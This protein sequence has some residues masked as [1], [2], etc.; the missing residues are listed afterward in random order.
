[1]AASHV[2]QTNKRLW[3]EAVTQLL[4]LSS[5]TVER[6]AELESKVAKLELELSVWKD[7]VE[8]EQKAHNAQVATL[9]HQLA[10][11]GV[12]NNQDPLILC[13]LDGNSS[14]FRQHLLAQG[15]QGGRHAAQELTKKI[16]EYLSQ[17]GVQVY[18]RLSFWI[19]IYINKRRLLGILPNEGICTGEQLDS[20]LSGFS[21]ASARFLVVDVGQGKDDVDVKLKEY[22]QTYLRFPQTLKVFFGGDDDTYVPMLEGIEKEKLTGKLVLLEGGRDFRNGL[23]QFALPS[24]RVEELFMPPGVS[25]AQQRPGP[26]PL[27]GFNNITTVGGLISPQSETQTSPSVPPPAAGIPIDPTKP[28]HKQTPPPC[29]EYYLMTCTKG[30]NCRYSHDWA[31]TPDQLEMLARSAKKAPC[32]YLKNGIDCPHG[33]RC[34]WGHI[35]PSGARCFHLS[36]GKCWFKAEGMHPALD[37]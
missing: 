8:R 24:M 23:Q 31:L 37:N 15:F 30:V 27:A 33:D 25:Q 21:Q 9:N 16:A 17:E 11:L 36:K 6:N 34:C 2:S 3:D 4:E 12:L 13:I 7:H 19:T 14:I 20:F 26:I 35:C 10:S 5:A 28:L 32:N 1:M 18:G 29:N 22:L